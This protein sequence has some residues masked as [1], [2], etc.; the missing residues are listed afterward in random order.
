MNPG[1]YSPLAWMHEFF[2]GQE[3]V[4]PL[5]CSATLHRELGVVVPVEYESR[6]QHKS[7]RIWSGHGLVIWPVID[8]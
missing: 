6:L 1:Y 2:P 4:G 7:I 3:V 5:V 8:W